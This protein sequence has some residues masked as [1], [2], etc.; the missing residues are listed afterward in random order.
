MN[1]FVLIRYY[2]DSH[3]E[4]L[5]LVG[6]MFRQKSGFVIVEPELNSDFIELNPNSQKH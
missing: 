6:L 1:A 2:N 5:F 4:G 3:Y